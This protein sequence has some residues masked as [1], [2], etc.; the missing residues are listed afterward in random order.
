[1]RDEGDGKATSW[2][3]STGSWCASKTRAG[4][5]RRARRWGAKFGTGIFHP[6]TRP[7]SSRQ[8][9]TSE[10]AP[11]RSLAPRRTLA[12][13]GTHTGLRVRQLWTAC[14]KRARAR[15]GGGMSYHHFCLVFT[16][17]KC[18]LCACMF[19]RAHT[20]KETRPGKRPQTGHQQ[21]EHT[22]DRKIN[23]TGAH[24]RGKQ[25]DRQSAGRWG[26]RVRKIE[27]TGGQTGRRR[28]EDGR[29]RERTPL[30]KGG[31]LAGRWA[32]RNCH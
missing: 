18:L 20:H 27:S 21:K 29:W 31:A 2:R 30:R 26:R 13:S 1:M 23:T 8:T 9:G 10:T 3:L 4:Q 14:R 22:T 32:Q 28:K 7:T 12:L 16:R 17:Q 19:A 5:Y 6:H 11:I 15:G 25:L 24:G